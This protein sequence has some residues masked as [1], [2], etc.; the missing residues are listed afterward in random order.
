MRGWT[1]PASCKVAAAFGSTTIDS[2]GRILSG[3]VAD[4]SSHPLSATT[5]ANIGIIG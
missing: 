1:M 5:I 2:S 4:R 3:G